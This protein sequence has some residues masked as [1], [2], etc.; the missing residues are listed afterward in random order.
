[1]LVE[2]AHKA[3][4]FG[5]SGQLGVELV[6][7][8]KARGFEVTGWERAAVDISDRDRVERVLTDLDPEVVFN[9]AAYNQVDV[10]DEALVGHICSIDFGEFLRVRHVDAFDLGKPGDARANFEHIEPNGHHFDHMREARKP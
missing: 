3:A 6:R 10:A 9:A 4:V 1:M 5:S 7:V 8:L 2:M